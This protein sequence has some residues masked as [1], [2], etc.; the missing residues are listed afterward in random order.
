MDLSGCRAHACVRWRTHPAANVEEH[1]SC[2][3]TQVLLV[4]GDGREHLV[5]RL[6]LVVTVLMGMLNRL[7]F[8]S[9]TGGLLNGFLERRSRHSTLRELHQG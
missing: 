8:Q 4:D 1:H 6:V 9:S 2:V 7:S 5:V 3:E